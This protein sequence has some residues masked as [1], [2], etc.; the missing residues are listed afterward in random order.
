MKATNKTIP[1]PEFDLQA[2]EVKLAELAELWKSK[3]VYLQGKI[4]SMELEIAQVLIKSVPVVIVNQTIKVRFNRESI[5][6]S[7]IH[8]IENHRDNSIELGFASKYD[9]YGYD[10]V[11]KELAIKNRLEIGKIHKIHI[12]G[13]RVNLAEPKDLIEELDYYRMVNFVSCAYQIRSYFIQFVEKQYEELL[14]IWKEMDDISYESAILDDKRKTYLLA[15]YEKDFT[16]MA[17]LKVGNVILIKNKE[18][19]FIHFYGYHITRSGPKNYTTASV[20]GE[21]QYL[22]DSLIQKN[23]GEGAHRFVFRIN[24]K[25]GNI[26]NETKDFYPKLAK[27]KVNGDKIVVMSFEDFKSLMDLHKSENLGILDNSTN[28]H[29]KERSDFYEAINFKKNKR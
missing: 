22:T 18:S 14:S 29:Y 21:T 26:S 19:D 23:Y 2:A 28:G 10:N 4:S 1:V 11:K 27:A 8:D 5:V 25:S 6:L 7:Y 20:K 9:I 13:V 24:V 15:V 3:Q 17:C 12:A 16:E